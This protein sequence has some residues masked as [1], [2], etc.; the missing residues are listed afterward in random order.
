MISGLASKFLAFFCCENDLK[1][2][3]LF[4]MLF[5]LGGGVA[6]TFF[7]VIILSNV[8]L[9]KLEDHSV[10]YWFLVHI[11]LFFLRAT[12][13]DCQSLVKLKILCTVS[14]ITFFL[15]CSGAQ[16][17]KFRIVPVSVDFWYQWQLVFLSSFTFKFR[18]RNA[19][20]LLQFGVSRVNCK[21]LWGEFAYSR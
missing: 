1:T 11:S 15:F 2:F 18:S 7:L 13:K 17:R 21:V 9:T 16:L 3:Y 4:Q 5:I 12:S 6:V 19:R 14:W 8:S 20:S 10:G